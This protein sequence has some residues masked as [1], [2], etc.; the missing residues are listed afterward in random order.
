MNRELARQ[1]NSGSSPRSA[2]ENDVDT[3]IHLAQ[4]TPVPEF[5][6]IDFLLVKAA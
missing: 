2:R 4:N 1:A 6:N 3:H 5:V